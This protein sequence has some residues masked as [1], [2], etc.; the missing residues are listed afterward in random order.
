MQ[1]LREAIMRVSSMGLTL[2]KDGV[3]YYILSQLASSKSS[4]VHFLFNC[5]QPDD[6]VARFVKP[7][8]QTVS[9]LEGTKGIFE[10]EQHRWD[11]GE[12][13]ALQEVI[14][15][16]TLICISDYTFAYYNIKRCIIP[17]SVQ[18]LGEGVFYGCTKLNT[19]VLP[20]NLEHIPT[21]LLANCQALQRIQLPPRLISIGDSAF[22]GTGLSEMI[23]PPTLQSIGDT[24][25]GDCLNLRRVRLNEGL[26]SIGTGVFS[27]CPKL[28]EIML[29][30][31]LKK[32]DDCAFMGCRLKT[33]YVPADIRDN[34][35]YLSLPVGCFVV[36]Y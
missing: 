13:T 18:R 20:Q 35:R 6:I 16:N 7:T 19:C 27:A 28:H 32:L 15:P 4:S 24:V 34:F 29:P 3:E 9:I 10:Y 33:I 12:N 8:G 36:A 17:D 5:L 30:Y 26:L 11:N 2:E 25:F 1:N 14:L 31:A 21:N 23:M 22:C